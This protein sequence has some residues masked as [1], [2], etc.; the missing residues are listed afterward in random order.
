[1]AWIPFIPREIDSHKEVLMSNPY[2]LTTGGSPLVQEIQDFVKSIPRQL[3]L[4]MDAE[5]VAYPREF[6]EE[7]AKRN[8]LGLRFGTQWGGRNLPWTSEMT[9]LEE[10]GTLGTALACLYSLVSIVG[11]AVHQFGSESQKE[12]YLKSILAGKVMVAEGLTEPRG[13][14]DFFAA[15]TQATRKGDHF[16]LDGQKRFVVGAEGADL[17]LVYGK[18]AGVDDPKKSNDCLPGG[19]VGR[20]NGGPRLRVDGDTRRRNRQACI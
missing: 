6:M 14:S 1:M 20:G 5:K 18:V 16:I 19:T 2:H 3:L 8:L 9:A 7:A 12:K 13:G 17:F 10:V 15:T 4:D 11:E